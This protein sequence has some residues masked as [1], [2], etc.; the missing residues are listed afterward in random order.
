MSKLISI[1]GNIGSGKSTLLAFLKENF[2]SLSLGE[3]SNEYNVV[4]LQE[5]VDSWMDIKNENNDSIL[6][7]F[8]EN[9]EKYAFSFQMMAY[10]SR[11]DLIKSVLNNNE[12]VLIISERSV[13]TDKHVF[14]QMLYDDNIMKSVEYQIYNKW[15]DSFIADIPFVGIVYLDVSPNICKQRIEK[16]NRN[17]ESIDIEYLKNCKKYHD[18]YVG[19]YNTLTLNG[20]CSFDDTKSEFMSNIT[21]FITSLM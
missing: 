12:K 7:L 8:Y 10:I 13:H 11:L 4:F 2:N 20:D 15:F 6:K 1:D 16:R 18:E 21:S 14:A 9:Q 17:G 5:P 3:Y 19:Q